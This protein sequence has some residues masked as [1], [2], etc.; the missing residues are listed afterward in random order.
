M[1]TPNAA[2][3]AHQRTTTVRLHDPSMP[4]GRTAAIAKPEAERRAGEVGSAVRFIGVLMFVTSGVSGCSGPQSAL[5]PAGRQA[6][7]IADL[8]WGMTIGGAA[9]WAAVVGM[10]VYAAYFSRGPHG[11]R[12]SRMLILGGGILFPVLVLTGLLTY[13]LWTL[14]EFL[15]PAPEG[16]LRVRVTGHQWW[17]RVRYLRHGEAPVDSANEIHLPAGEP[18]EFEL[19]APDVIHSFWIPSIAGKVDMIPGRQTRLKIEPSRLGIYRGACA[20]YCGVS[21]A[22]MAFY[23]VVQERGEFDAWLAAQARSAW[24]PSGREA[25]RGAAQF[26]ANGCGACHTIRGTGAGGIVGP[27]LTHV[28]SRLS[29]GAGVLASSPSEIRRWIALTDDVKPG[30]HMPRFGMLPEE[31]LQELSI[32]LKGLQ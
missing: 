14:P 24:E 25:R 15:A 8:F 12:T 20:E 22:L 2:S 30:V 3:M 1:T 18:V 13:S 19:D 10:T 7:R 29:I 4:K 26:V 21:H 27:D 16:A 17:W 6:S 31:A 5:D 28:G 11:P 32:Y 9:I 23:A